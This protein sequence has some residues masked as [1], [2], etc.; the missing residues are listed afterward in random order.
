MRGWGRERAGT[1]DPRRALCWQQWAEGGRSTNWATQEPS[2]FKEMLLLA[3]RNASSILGGMGWQSPT[4][5]QLLVWGKPT[6]HLAKWSSWDNL[7]LGAGNIPD[8][9]PPKKWFVVSGRLEDSSRLYRLRHFERTSGINSKPSQQCSVQF[10]SLL[11]FPNGAKTA[12]T[13]GAYVFKALRAA[14]FQYFRF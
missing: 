5:P 14:S 12:L 3:D 9:Q 11:S 7:L 10:S 2:P 1:E 13:N 6:S 8:K 4:H